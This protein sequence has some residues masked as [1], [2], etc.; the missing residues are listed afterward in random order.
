MLIVVISLVIGLFIDSSSVKIQRFITTGFSEYNLSIFSVLFIVLA[1]G[2]LIVFLILRRKE[3]QYIPPVKSLYAAFIAVILIQIALQTLILLS[4]LDMVFYAQYHLMYIVIS[5]VTSYVFSSTMIFYLCYRF[6]KWTITNFNYYTLAY[7]IA[8]FAIGMNIILTLMYVLDIT[9]SQ[10]DIVRFHLGHISGVGRYIL[11]QDA[12]FVSSIIAYV[13]TWGATAVLMYHYK[14]RVGKI[15]YYFTTLLPLVFF[16]SQFNPYLSQLLVD[17]RSANPTFFGISYVIFFSA[18]IPL[19]AVIFG[20]GLRLQAS[21]LS[22]GKQSVKNYL[23][24]ASYGILLLFS[25]NQA[26][27]LVNFSYPPF[28]L[29]TVSMLG[30]SSFLLT[31]G[32][33]SSAISVAN[34]REILKA[35]RNSVSKES[36]LLDKMGTATMRD[37]LERRILDITNSLSHHLTEQSGLDPS[38]SESDVQKYLKEAIEET[39]KRKPMT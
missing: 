25:S 16:M 34:D 21:S 26:V 14:S 33:Y 22:G 9:T 27:V 11:L 24:L 23:A 2:Q 19:G 10:P 17:Y 30:L 32:I 7:G 3:D 35:V 36:S 29:M 12:Y 1:L 15:K 13:G 28:G 39:R 37:D 18:S 6:I 38:L 31:L 5:V 4:I 8:S 20:F